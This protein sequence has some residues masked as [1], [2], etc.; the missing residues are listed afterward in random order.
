MLILP[1]P[2]VS[3]EEAKEEFSGEGLWPYLVISGRAR[4]TKGGAMDVMDRLAEFYIG[5]GKQ[6]PYR[7]MPDG[8]VFSDAFTVFDLVVFRSHFARPAQ[9][10]Q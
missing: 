7:D 9:L 1:P 5:P 8:V 3:I 4:V 10:L 2:D 6:Y